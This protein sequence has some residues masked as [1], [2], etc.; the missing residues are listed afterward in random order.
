MTDDHIEIFEALRE[1]LR[2]G[3]T[4]LIPMFDTFYDTA[5]QALELAT[6]RWSACSISERARA[7]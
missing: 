7:F 6:G 3:A 1:R 5:V 4:R 2:R